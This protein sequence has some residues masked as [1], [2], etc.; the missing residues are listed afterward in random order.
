M[1]IP[2]HVWMLQRLAKVLAEARSSEAGAASTTKWLGQ[3]RDGSEL[4][5]LDDRLVDCRVRREGA[6]LFSVG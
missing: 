1:V 5:E 4:L 2:Y 6:R 3:F